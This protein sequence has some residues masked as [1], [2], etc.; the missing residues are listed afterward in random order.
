MR[1]YS[2]FAFESVVVHDEQIVAYYDSCLR[3]KAVVVMSAIGV[4]VDDA[5]GNRSLPTVIR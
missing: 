3:R 5:K 1:E 4:A 2:F